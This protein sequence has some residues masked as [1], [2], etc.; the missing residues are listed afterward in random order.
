MFRSVVKFQSFQ[1]TSHGVDFRY[2]SRY[3]ENSRS[4]K[5]SFLALQIY[6]TLSIDQTATQSIFRE[7]MFQDFSYQLI[8]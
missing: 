1:A 7:L 6:V 5:T 4:V 3:I 8:Q 2:L